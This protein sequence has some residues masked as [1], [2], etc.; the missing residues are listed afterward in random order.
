M[1]VLIKYNQEWLLL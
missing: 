1:K